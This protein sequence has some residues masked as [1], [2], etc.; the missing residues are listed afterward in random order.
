MIKAECGNYSSIAFSEDD[1]ECW[2]TSGSFHPS[3]I[4]GKVPL[5]VTL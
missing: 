3:I 5:R 2:T 1:R 4:E